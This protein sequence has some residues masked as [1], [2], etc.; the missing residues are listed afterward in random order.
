MR[1]LEAALEA[2]QSQLTGGAPASGSYALPP[3]MALPP[4]PPSPP[5]HLPHPLAGGASAASLGGLPPLPPLLTVQD[6]DVWLGTGPGGA[7]AGRGGGGGVLRSSSPMHAS[8]GVG[9]GSVAA[10]RLAA[11]AYEN[12]G[13]VS[14]RVSLQL[15]ASVQASQVRGRVGMTCRRVRTRSETHPG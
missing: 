6:S 13:V 2:A 11:Y 8:S 12:G 4:P 10:G 7:A 9:G 3:P 14:P 5:P 1:I 15:P